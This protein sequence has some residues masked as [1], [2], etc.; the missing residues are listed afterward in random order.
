MTTRSRNSRARSWAGLIVVL[1]IVGGLLGLA[2]SPAGALVVTVTSTAD[3]GGPGTLRTAVE[4]INATGSGP[5]TIILGSGLTYQLTDCTAAN[6]LVDAGV[7]P[8]TI[9]GNGSTIEQACP[10]ERVLRY[11]ATELLTINA[12]TITGG[13]RTGNASGVKSFGPVEIN[14]STITGN[15]AD[16]HGAGVWTEDQDVTLNRSVV[17][18]NRADDDEDGEGSGGGV[19]AGAARVTV[20]NS[21]IA[22]NH[23]HL[24]GGIFAHYIDLNFATIV[25]NEST[26]AGSNV[27]ATHT[28]TTFGSVFA[29]PIGGVN[30]ANDANVSLGYNYSTDHS[31]GL[32]GTGDVGDGGDPRLGALTDN[33]GPTR[34]ALPLEGSPL[35]DAILTSESG[36]AGTDQRGV[37]RPQADGCDIGAVEVKDDVP[38]TT[39]TLPTTTTAI[40]T[41]TVAARP[42]ALQPSFTG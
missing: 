34:T 40:P 16:R 35:V 13:D 19:Y 17:V 29:Y 25:R 38:V 24:G 3:D 27:N 8:L 31:C 5:H 2:P 21:T 28:M 7:G 33:G 42:S 12:T 23:A 14:D 22:D 32:T 4:T 9:S 37:P 15:R 36:C 10:G 30:C 18:D 39:T 11:N 26:Q 41:T 6:L 20:N 1:S